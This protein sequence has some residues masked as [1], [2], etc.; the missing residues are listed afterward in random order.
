MTSSTHDAVPVLALTGTATTTKSDIIESL[1]LS[2]P[3][4]VESNPDRANI[5]YASHIRPGR[6]DEKLESSLQPVVSE[7]KTLRNEMPLTLIH[8]NLETIAECFKYFS[9][10]MGKEQYY[11]STAEPLAKNR[12]FTQ[13]HAQYPEHERNRIV[14][15]MVKGT[16]THRILFL[17]LHLA[18]ELTAMT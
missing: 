3:L 4:M 16:S 10:S 11:P 18:L 8:G 17:P 15:E 14:E 13:Y 6:G 7:L 9:N 1:G 2:N 5:Y 12:L